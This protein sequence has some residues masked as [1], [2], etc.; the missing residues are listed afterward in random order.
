MRCAFDW[1]CSIVQLVIATILVANYWL[2]EYYFHTLILIIPSTWT[3]CASVF[4]LWMDFPLDGFPLWTV[5]RS[6]WFSNLD[7]SPL[8]TDFCSGSPLWTDFC[9][10]WTSLWTVFRSGRFSALDG[11]LLWISALDG[12]LLWTV[13]RSGRTS[14]LDELL[15]H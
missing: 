11:L 9:S 3:L 8:W 4:L 13:F 6:G 7:S 15:S 5:L 14:A 12:F 10:G 2:L 1:A